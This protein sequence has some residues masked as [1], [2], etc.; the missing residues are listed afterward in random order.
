MQ[1]APKLSVVMPVYNAEKFLPAAIISIIN[2]TF[3]D[4][5]FIII[6]D[7][8]SDDSLKIIK[9][10]AEEDSRIQVISR[11]NKG[12]IYSLN[13]ALERARGQFIAR[14]DG[15][16]ISLPF[17]FERQL[18]FMQ[19]K[20]VDVCGCHFLTINED[21]KKIDSTLVPLTQDSLLANLATT[22]PFAHGSVMMRREFLLN[23]NLR[24]GEK[25]YTNA[26][27]Y[28][29]WTDM[30][31]QGARFGNVDDFLFEYREYSTSLSKMN[32]KNLKLDAKK[33][34]KRFMLDNQHSLY[35][36]IH[37]Q[38]NVPLSQEEKNQIIACILYLSVYSRSLGL[39]GCLSKLP[40]RNT[41]TV[42]L[43]LIYRSF[44]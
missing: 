19:S 17:R 22:A 10:F 6:D 32:T 28:A 24:Y 34:S 14:M 29:L 33:I 11:E 38:V 37:R 8:S 26:E 35:S 16:D 7:G 12:L 20:C 42:L 2:Q 31:R 1:S 9:R 36:M 43:K 39:L 21:D 41:V 44:L 3:T 30:Y 25:C 18:A 15:D 5:E 13:E 27:D 23:E 4:Y 40:L